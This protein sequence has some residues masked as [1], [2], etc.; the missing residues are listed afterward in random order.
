MHRFRESFDAAAP[1]EP[2]FFRIASRVLVDEF[3][4]HPC[5]P[6]GSRFPVD[7]RY[8]GDLER[9]AIASE[10]VALLLGGLTERQRSVLVASKMI[11]WEYAEIAETIGKSLASVKQMASRTLRML[12]ARP[13]A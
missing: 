6:P 4:K 8:A 7:D 11:G 3:R 9:Q 5:V 12:R 1:F 2:W 10:E 13:L